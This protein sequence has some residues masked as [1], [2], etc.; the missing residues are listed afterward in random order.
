MRRGIGE[1]RAPALSAHNAIGGKTRMARLHAA[2]EIEHGTM[3]RG[4]ENAIGTPREH[5]GADQRLLHG[6]YI[7]TALQRQA[8]AEFAGEGHDKSSFL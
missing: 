6:A 1:K 5:A 8:E 7:I 4:A 3:R 2:L